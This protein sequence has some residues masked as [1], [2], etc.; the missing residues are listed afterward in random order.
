MV[1]NSASFGLRNTVTFLVAF[2]GFAAASSVTKAPLRPAKLALNAP[3]VSPSLL[4]LDDTFLNVGGEN[5]CSGRLLNADEE[6]ALAREVQRLRSYEDVR[7]TLGE[8]PRPKSFTV[9]EGAGEPIAASLADYRLQ[10]QVLR[11]SLGGVCPVCTCPPTRPSALSSVSSS[12]DLGRCSA[13][14]PSVR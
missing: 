10:S 5:A 11:L 6:V 7:A 3:R 4:N 2:S 14:A 8:E 13:R 12:L 9:T 1:R